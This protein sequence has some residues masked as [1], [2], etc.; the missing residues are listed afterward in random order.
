MKKGVIRVLLTVLIGLGIAL[1]AAAARGFHPGLPLPLL[2]RY[3]SDGC[4]VTAVILCGIGTLTLISSTGFFDIFS[5]GMGTLWAHIS[6]IWKGYEHIRFY[7]Y[8]A[9]RAEKRGKSLRFVLAVG[10]FY[11]AVSVLLLILYYSIT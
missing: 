10:L 4:F 11:L 8:K 2:C 5:Y 7:D 9:M 3:G 1:W 6:S